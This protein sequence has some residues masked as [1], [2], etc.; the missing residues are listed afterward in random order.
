MLRR[1]TH[2]FARI[3][4]Y[5]VMEIVASC[6]REEE[7]RDAYAEIYDRVIAG[8]ERFEADSNRSVQRLTPSNN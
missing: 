8:L 7:K 5:K 4:S 6:W 3:N 2:D 1:S